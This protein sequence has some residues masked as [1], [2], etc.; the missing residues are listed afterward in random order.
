MRHFPFCHYD[1][2]VKTTLRVPDEI[3][4]ELRLR[5]QKEGRSL[6][7]TAVDALRR[8]L[9]R[10]QPATS[11]SDVLGSFVDQPA[12]TDFDYEALMRRL[13]GIDTSGLEEAL[14]WTRG[15]Y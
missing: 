13:D 10:T 6:N 9:G 14:E 12:S 5:S 2:R 1:G 7:A 15:E 11:A 4:D 3:L 8:G